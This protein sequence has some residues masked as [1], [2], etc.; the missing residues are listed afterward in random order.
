MDNSKLSCTVMKLWFY[1]LILLHL[2]FCHFI[3]VTVDTEGSYC[4]DVAWLLW[5][6]PRGEVHPQ[7]YNHQENSQFIFA[8]CHAEANAGVVARNKAQTL[9]HMRAWG[10]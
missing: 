1:L 2:P 6:G 4:K 8:R 5:L 3:W 9:L 7:L 10:N